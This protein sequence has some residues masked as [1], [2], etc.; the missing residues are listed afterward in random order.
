MRVPAIGIVAFFACGVALGQAPWIA[1]RAS[2]HSFVII[3]LV[4]ATSLICSGFF[5]TRSTRLFPAAMASALSWFFLGLIGAGIAEQPRPSGFV[6]SLLNAGRIDLKTPLRWHGRLRDEPARLPWGYGYEIQLTGVEF[7]GSLVHTRGGLRLNLTETPEEMQTPAPD[8]HSG[9]EVTVVA[10]AKLPQIYRDD[11][12][13]DRRAYLEQQNIDLIASLRAPQLMERTKAA[14]TTPATLLARARRRLRDEID[15][16][17]AG[18]PQVDGVLRA[19]LLGDRSFVDRGESLD[20]QKTGVF[21]VLVVAGLHVGALAV[22]LFWM[23]RAL[24]L[25]PLWTALMTLTLLLAYLAVVEQRPPVLR[26]ALMT[27]I[28]VV[29]GLFFRRLDLLNSV[30]IAALILLVAKPLALRDSSFQLTFLAIGCI[31]GLAV[32]WLET[33]V[34]PFAKALRGWRDVTRDASHE[35]RAAQFRID[36]R[37][38]ARWIEALLPARLS[39]PA[40]TMFV[41]S[42]GIS[43]RVWELLVITLV[44]Q[45]GMLP[46]MASDFHRVTLSAPLVNLAAVP[47]TGIVVPLGFLTLGGGLFS[48]TLGKLLATPLAWITLLL[49]HIV[50]WF[51]H[52]PHWSYRIPGPPA[53]LILLFLMSGVFLAIT[54]RGPN[55]WHAWSARSAGVVLALSALAIALFPFAPKWSRGKLELTVLDVGQGDSLFVVSPGGE[56]MLIDGGGAFGGFSGRE[57]HNGSDPGEEAVSPYLW[58]R[59]F[60]KLDIVALTH[61]HQDHIGGLTAILENFHVGTLWIGREVKSQALANLE[62]LAREKKIQI[63][64]EFRGE[65]FSWGG[66]RT[67]V[68]WP[69]IPPS[70]V[71][72]SPQNNDSL[73]LR[74]Q[75]GERGIM[76]PGDAEKQAESSM[77]ADNAE[78]TMS[79]DVLKVGHHGSK[80]STMPGFLA[81][82][83]PRIAVISAGE[84]N[85]YGHPNPE[86]LDRLT[87]AGVRILRTDRD[88]A[89]HVLTDGKRTEI[90]CY[91]PCR[92]N[93]GKT[94]SAEPHPPDEKKRGEQ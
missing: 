87:S 45:I 23:G 62:K 42:I 3:S 48:T 29:G 74:M 57:E 20:F 40:G 53:W 46:L 32:P 21:H 35:P 85:L 19:M 31:A 56:T 90:S 86:L 94:A 61:A 73:V 59:G 84:G 92:E 78:Q 27:A 6:L 54:A 49:L 26:A 93:A 4:V 24:R 38:T 12:A 18:R 55:L 16:L 34:Q 9:D 1:G 79:A 63:V 76:L 13:F 33:K 70:E 66:V 11:G 83:H 81:A 72:P 80:N 5:L 91:V 2:S 28:V 77:L 51:A 37:S 7:E 89:V 43:L 60:Q 50:Q 47:L 39:G 64:H 17:F 14:S 88:G 67:Q 41:S 82:V 58:S 68:L 22:F 25:A 75:Y 8:V 44:L 30:G 36:L 10:L 52:F 65:P 69:E 71:G 15:T